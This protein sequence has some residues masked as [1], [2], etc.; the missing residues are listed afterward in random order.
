MKVEIALN[1]YTN[2]SLDKT[3]KI[4]NECSKKPFE[5]A[6]PI[7]SVVNHSIEFYS[8][9]QAKIFKPSCVVVVNI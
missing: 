4:L 7:P 1:T 3:L 9:E 2:V 8:H 5:K 6:T